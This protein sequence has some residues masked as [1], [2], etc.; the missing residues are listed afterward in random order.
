MQENLKFKFIF[1]WIFRLLTVYYNSG[2]KSDEWKNMES[3]SIF[4]HF[5]S[6]FYIFETF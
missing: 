6:Q 1:S 4:F 5:F 3:D 2:T